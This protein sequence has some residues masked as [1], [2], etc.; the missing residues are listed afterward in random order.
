MLGKAKRWFARTPRAELTE[1]LGEAHIPAFKVNVMRLLKQLRDEDSTL[2]TIA[3]TAEADPGL[4]VRLLRAVNS[5]A[6]GLRRQVDNV[7]HAISLLGRSE[8][9]TLTLT[10]A[11]RGVIPKSDHAD[12][13][14]WQLASRRAAIARNLAHQ[15][16]PSAASV[17][18]SAGLLQD[19]AI[20]LLARSR[21]SYREM[22]ADV[23]GEEMV[24]TEKATYGF[25]HPEVAGWLCECW[26]FPDN[27][28]EA[29][30]G[31]HGH[32]DDAPV[33]VLLVAMIDRGNLEN[34]DEIIER[35]NER[36]GLDTDV[37]KTAVENGRREGDALARALAAK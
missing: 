15:V 9:E 25:D 7:Q 27:L 13:K 32:G 24:H 12:R 19:L 18:F 3:R 1:A 6:Y 36:F 11:V 31:H 5:P 26:G 28:Q 17:S 16:Q 20:P 37:V 29:I 21:P 23:S 14:F 2:A 30:S 35:A 4:T 10:M 22:L 33:P 8:L 34:P